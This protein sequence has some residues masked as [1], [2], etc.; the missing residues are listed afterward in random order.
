MIFNKK[1]EKGYIALLSIIIV[2]SL[3]LLAVSY[4]N[5]AS[6]NEAKLG[7]K[8]SHSEESFYLA[9]ACAE[10]ALMRLK[11]DL[12]YSGGEV[13]E[14]SKG[15]CNILSLEGAGNEDR[16]IK[17]LGS[18]ADI[19]RRIRIVIGSVNP[20]TEIDSWEEVESF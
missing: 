4:F 3:L 1:N 13:L 8:E 12:G 15:E 2:S 17:T 6:I 14:F 11:E 9:Q 5:L 10:E 7:L 16:I 20:Q 19:T 18:V